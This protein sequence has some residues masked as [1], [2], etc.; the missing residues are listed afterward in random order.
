[1]WQMTSFEKKKKN[2]CNVLNE[3]CN[4]RYSV[5]L[6]SWTWAPNYYIVLLRS[7][8]STM[9]QK[10]ILTLVTFL[11]YVSFPKIYNSGITVEGKS[12]L[13]LPSAFVSCFQWVRMR[14]ESTFIIELQTN[15]IFLCL[16]TFSN[17]SFT[18]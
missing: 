15:D 4:S 5:H 18:Y 16:L 10:P 1:M 7:T 14:G 12:V 17:R 8:P 9:F 6:V 11:R 3:L 13:S 2:N